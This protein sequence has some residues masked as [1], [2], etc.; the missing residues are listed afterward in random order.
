MSDII[1]LL[2]DSVANQIAAGEVIQR[3]ASVVKELV[4][5]AVDAGA[6]S[7]DILIKD[8]GRTLIQ[9]TDNGKGMSPMDARMAFERH[10]TSKI[11]SAN[12]LFAISTNGF[13]GEALASIAAV[14]EVELKTKQEDDDIG[15]RLII[16]SSKCEQEEPISGILGTCIAVKNLF[17]N[18]PARRKFLKKDA[19]ELKH[20]INEVQ[21]TAIANNNISFKLIH[22]KSIIYSLPP[23]NRKKRIVDIFGKNMQQNLVKINSETESVKIDGYI[24]L[25]QYAKK[26]YGDQYMFVN[27]R[28]VRHLGIHKMLMIAYE[29]ILSSKLNPSYFLFI[30]VDP[31]TIDINI[32]PQKTEIKFENESLIKTFC[33]AA[34]REALGKNNIAPSIDFDTEGRVDM[35]SVANLNEDS[36]IPSPEITIDEN[37]NP[38]ESILPTKTSPKNT[39]AFSS[40]RFAANQSKSYLDEDNSSHWQTAY[41]GLN[42]IDKT[43]QDKTEIYQSSLDFEGAKKTAHGKSIQL[44]YKYIVTP[45]ESGLMIIDQKLAHE[46]ILYENFFATSKSKTLAGQGFLFGESIELSADKAV[47]LQQTMPELEK[48]GIE[49]QQK[50]DTTFEINSM[51]QIIRDMNHQELII[52]LLDQ[53]T[54]ENTTV[55]D[56][57]TNTIATHIADITSIPHGK[58][59]SAIEIETLISDLFACT[60]VNYSPRGKKIFTIITMEQLK[61][62]L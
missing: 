55:A 28:Y 17:F 9:I 25:P 60:S 41:S 4:D 13:R 18:I 43:E 5:N 22:N 40:G 34:A 48:L 29:Q 49:L 27:N 47:L 32:H 62:M 6:S 8:A 46:R 36:I 15:T 21:R 31:S 51:P 54:E 12:D 11:R 59:L 10:A 58:S 24:G 42:N 38:F 16:K 57:A 37:Y 1:K 26:T 50:N 61:S 19:T 2:P 56:I 14:A 44:K 3:P 35:P 45:V 39:G 53:L 20:I 52:S 33:L 7:I 30:D 23:S